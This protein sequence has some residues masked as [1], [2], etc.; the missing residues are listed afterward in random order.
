MTLYMYIKTSQ[1][2]YLNA[3]VLPLCFVDKSRIVK[4]LASCRW[5]I[6]SFELP[7]SISIRQRPRA[8]WKR[9]EKDMWSL[10]AMS[11]VMLE[12]P[13]TASDSWVQHGA[14]WVRQGPGGPHVGPMNFAIWGIM[15]ERALE[16]RYI[17]VPKF[18]VP[19]SYKH[20]SS[21]Q[22]LVIN[23]LARHSNIKKWLD[24]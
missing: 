20:V 18:I 15:L 6:K 24:N 23:K 21:Q 13:D 4:S 5:Q 11:A 10:T 12:L 19:L 22:L 1:N 3:S 8:V 14:L 2:R 16:I 7:L 9:Y 17:S